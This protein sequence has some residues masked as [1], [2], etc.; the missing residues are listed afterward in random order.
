MGQGGPAD[1][2]R[3]FVEDELSEAGEGGCGGDVEENTVSTRFYQ[4]NLGEGG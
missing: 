4:E 1:G 2:K 3:S